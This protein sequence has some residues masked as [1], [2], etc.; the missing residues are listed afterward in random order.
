MEGG[1]R[2]SLG[3]SDRRFEGADCCIGGVKGATVGSGAKQTLGLGNGGGPFAALGNGGGPFAPTLALASGRGLKTTL[4]RCKG[5]ALAGGDK[6]AGASPVGCSA[7]GPPAGA[8]ADWRP[9]RLASPEVASDVRV[10]MPSESLMS[11]EEQL[12]T[13]SS[14][15]AFAC[16]R[17]PLSECASSMEGVA[18]AGW[19]PLSLA[20]ADASPEVAPSAGLH[21]GGVGDAGAVGGAGGVDGGSGGGTSG[22]FAFAF[23]GFARSSSI[24]RPYH[25]ATQSRQ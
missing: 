22:A 5:E 7:V 13:G 16:W 21:G 12:R 18:F 10:S 20:A 3:P 17:P 1:G 2:L 9:L 15:V 6:S 24:G 25:W 11:C 23:G 14:G 4:G 8:F 19:R